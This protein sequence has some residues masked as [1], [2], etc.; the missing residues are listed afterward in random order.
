MAVTWSIRPSS[1]FNRVRIFY[2]HSS[3]YD[4]IYAYD[5]PEERIVNCPLSGAELERG[6]DDLMR[7]YGAPLE[8]L[9]ASN[10]Q[11][12][13]VQEH[14]RSIMVPFM[15]HLHTLVNDGELPAHIAA[16]GRHRREREATHRLSNLVPMEYRAP[17]HILGAGG[18][19]SAGT[20]ASTHA[21]GGN[22]RNSL[23]LDFHMLEQQV[24]EAMRVLP[25]Q[26]HGDVL[27]GGDALGVFLGGPSNKEADIKAERTL[28]AYMTDD[29]RIQFKDSGTF[30]VHL[31]GGGEARI[32]SK[33]SFN[34][35]LLS[36]TPWARPGEYC[37]VP[38]GDTLPLC[39]QLLIQ[40]LW[41]ET[42]PQH[43]FMRA[44]ADHFSTP[45]WQYI[46]PVN[47]PPM[48]F[49]IFGDTHV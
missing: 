42:N 26:L 37:G 29:Q 41:L 32:S 49:N 23:A 34:V 6:F 17:R 10:L 14:M 44:N 5:L 1:D 24:A 22:G 33:R 7:F 43:F 46:R 18:G 12:V 45:I 31:K 8:A 11:L 38:A 4:L 47:R 40:K 35:K 19:S 39:D 3:H 25:E 16:A 13:E 27:Y 15:H 36:H 2:I 20:S 30:I 21:T 48:R 28:F 9:E